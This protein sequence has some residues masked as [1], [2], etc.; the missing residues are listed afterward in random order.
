MTNFGTF[1]KVNFSVTLDSETET[2]TVR[3]H[4]KGRDITC[5]SLNINLY[6]SINPT[7]AAWTP[8]MYKDACKQAYELIV[9][10]SQI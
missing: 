6:H 2:V 7:S 8:K 1:R 10:Y 5:T 3:A 4:Y 9:S